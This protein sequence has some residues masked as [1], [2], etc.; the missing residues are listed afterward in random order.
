MVCRRTGFF[1]SC[2]KLEIAYLHNEKFLLIAYLV[3]I[4]TTWNAGHHHWSCGYERPWSSS[5]REQCVTIL[6]PFSFLDFFKML[7]LVFLEIDVICNFL[8]CRFLFS[9]LNPQQIHFWDALI[10][11]LFQRCVIDTEHWCALMVHLP[12]H[13]TRRHLHLGLT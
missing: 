6:Q 13:W 10:L 7:H 3:T 8:P 5:E 12:H 11:N 9:S 4:T 2:G 1:F